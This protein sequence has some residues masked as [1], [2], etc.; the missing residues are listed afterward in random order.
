MKIKEELKGEDHREF[1]LIPKAFGLLELEAKVVATDANPVLIT[2]RIENTT[3]ALVAEFK[4]MLKE[5]HE[6][7]E[8]ADVEAVSAGNN[9]EVGN[10]IAEAM[11]KVGC[12]G[13]VT[14][15]EGKSF[16]ILLQLLLTLLDLERGRV[17]ILTTLLLL[18]ETKINQG[19]Q[20]RM[21]LIWFIRIRFCNSGKLVMFFSEPDYNNET[22]A[23]INKDCELGRGGQKVHVRVK[24]MLKEVD[25][26][27]ELAD[28]EAVSAGNNYELGNM[29]AEAMAKVGCKG[30][31]T[32]EEGKSFVILLQLLLRLLD[33]ERGRVSTL[34][35][36][37]LLWEGSQF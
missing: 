29:I 16:V 37:L 12:K 25:K 34:T 22:N 7:S 17:S 23:L 33:L 5:V 11:A 6:D 35:T 13:V 27:S 32:L 8:L 18:W 10:M 3:K 28:V 26:D 14:L 30:V 15:E 24:K 19:M 20:E 21:T 1:S 36:L 31:V 4:K 9:Y 2:R